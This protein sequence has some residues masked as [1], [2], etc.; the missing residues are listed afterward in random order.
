[1]FDKT[2]CLPAEASTYR[3][4][5][6]TAKGIVSDIGEEA[7]SASVGLVEFSRCNENRSE[8]EGLRVIQKNRVTLPVPITTLE[9]V[10][11]MRFRGDFSIIRLK[12]WLQFI[13]GHNA[14]HML[15]GLAKPNQ[16]REEKILTEWWRKYRLLHPDHEIW[17]LVDREGPDSLPL[18]RTF[19]LLFHGDEGRG[20]KRSAFLVCAF[21][22]YIGFGT[23]LANSKRSVRPFL[24]LRLNYLGNTHA[25]RLLTACMPKAVED[26]V[27]N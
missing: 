19:P 10:P 27:V 8:R 23:S 26:E 13:I 1:M 18:N 6:R 9:R 4:A 5:I 17:K 21:H 16:E 2:F 7:C 11:G 25:N 15:V 14:Q 12:D 20:K 24:P 22:S 3:S